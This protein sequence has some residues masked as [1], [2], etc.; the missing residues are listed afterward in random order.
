MTSNNYFAIKLTFEKLA[1]VVIL[2]FCIYVCAIQKRQT[3]QIHQLKSNLAQQKI[4][5][6]DFENKVY[7][8]DDKNA[9]LEER[10]EELQNNIIQLENNID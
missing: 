2:L 7:E 10:I 3:K 1:L 5:L 4:Y 9:E 6:D 8:L